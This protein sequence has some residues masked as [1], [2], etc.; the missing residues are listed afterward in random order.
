LGGLI[1]RR[2]LQRQQTTPAQQALRGVRAGDDLAQKLGQELG[3]GEVLLQRLPQKE[4]GRARLRHLLLV[5][6]DQLDP[7]VDRGALGLRQRLQMQK[8]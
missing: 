7:A 8:A 2:E 4:Q 6:G 3:R 1:P 5:P